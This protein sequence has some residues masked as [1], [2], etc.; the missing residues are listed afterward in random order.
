MPSDLGREICVFANA[1]GGVIPIGVADV[2]TMVG[3]KDHKRL[4]SPVQ[5]LARSADPTVAVG[6]ESEGDMVYVT[7][8][9]QHG[10]PYSFGGRFL[11]RHSSSTPYPSP[12]LTIK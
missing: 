3:V 4:R 8:P 6:V 5:S 9:E 2:G 1:T 11:L 10:K 7:V 12:H